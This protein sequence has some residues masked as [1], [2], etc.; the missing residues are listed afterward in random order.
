LGEPQRIV[1]SSTERT[2]RPGVEIVRPH[3]LETARATEPRPQEAARVLENPQMKH[4]RF[5]AAGKMLS[6]KHSGMSLAGS[7]VV[8]I[9]EGDESP[10]T[11]DDNDDNEDEESW[12][13]EGFGELEELSKPRKP[14]VRFADRPLSRTGGR[15]MHIERPSSRLGRRVEIA[16]PVSRN[17][18]R[19]E[20]RKPR[21]IHR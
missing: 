20:A 16:R 5:E 10:T 13:D 15:A 8:E 21:I 18:Q 19:V 1:N 12:E 14:T 2:L 7:M 11:S 17:S 4:L 3:V 6:H 9:G